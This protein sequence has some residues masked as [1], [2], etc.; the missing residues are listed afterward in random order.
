MKTL[1]ISTL[2]VIISL[3]A[4]SAVAQTTTDETR[5]LAAQA[6]AEQQREASTRPPV[7]EPVAAG[8]YRAQ[9]QQ[10]ERVLQWQAT[11]RAVRAYAAG[12]RS[13]PLTVNSED[14]ARAEAQRVHAEQAL[15][16]RAAMLR[17]AA[18]AQ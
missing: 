9:A 7:A 4:A 14:S 10:H 8:D 5:A 13:Q 6:T 18:A 1:T 15:A 16:E 3:L 2:P 17:T 12:V 11:Q